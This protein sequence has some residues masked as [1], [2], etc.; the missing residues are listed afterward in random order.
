MPYNQLSLFPMLFPSATVS[1]AQAFQ[2]IKDFYSQLKNYNP[3]R[4][5]EEILI[6]DAPCVQYGTAA[7][8]DGCVFPE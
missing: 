2:N 5:K 8:Q 3:I 7:A 4:C 1:N 6:T